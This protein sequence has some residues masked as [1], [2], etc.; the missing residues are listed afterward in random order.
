MVPL[1]LP[2]DC[3]YYIDR[4]FGD[5][6]GVFSGMH[7]NPLR[8]ECVSRLP[9]TTFHVGGA[10]APV[11]IDLWVPGEETALVS[12]TDGTT[13]C[14]VDGVRVPDLSPRDRLLQ[15]LE[16]R[17]EFELEPAPARGELPCV[18]APRPRLSAR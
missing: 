2:N 5:T 16:S 17:W 8:N 18:L 11:R 3:W 4:T 9:C 13:W 1:T 7:L 6:A 12:G 10:D 15:Q 14:E